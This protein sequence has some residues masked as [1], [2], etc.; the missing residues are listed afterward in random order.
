MDQHIYIHMLASNFHLQKERV[1][2]RT[3]TV[4][5]NRAGACISNVENFCSYSE[6]N[7]LHVVHLSYE[8][9][10]PPPPPPPKLKCIKDE[11]LPATFYEDTLALDGWARGARCHSMAA[12]PPG[13]SPVPIWQEA[14]CA[15]GLVWVG[16]GEEVIP[17][18]L[19]WSNPGQFSL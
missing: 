4:K 18:L 13:V 2:S 10:S 6:V 12:V 17:Y 16:F 9:F 5:K 11:V 14:G 7:L 8:V 19:W 1:F 15:S 3:S